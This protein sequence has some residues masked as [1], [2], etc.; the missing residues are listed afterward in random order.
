MTK[1][2]LSLK[3]NVDCFYCCY[4]LFKIGQMIV[5]LLKFINHRFD[6]QSE[7]ENLEKFRYNTRR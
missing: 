7:S 2:N 1:L 6:I 4:Y 3:K 5:S